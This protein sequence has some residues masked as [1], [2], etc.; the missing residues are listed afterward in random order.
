MVAGDETKRVTM[1]LPKKLVSKLDV[2]SRAL[3]KDRTEVTKEAIR[4]FIE[5]FEIDSGVRK[6]AI[7]EYLEGNLDYEDLETTLGPYDAR[8][9]KTAQDVY[10]R[11]GDLADQIADDL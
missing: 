7:E 9:V 6:I 10:D 2:I 11:G 5:E 4:E 3:F 8:A 1:N